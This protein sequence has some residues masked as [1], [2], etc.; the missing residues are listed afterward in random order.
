M[1]DDAFVVLVNWLRTCHSLL[2][3]L[4]VYIL[5]TSTI[6]LI[7]K[8][9]KYV[10]LCC[11][12]MLCGVIANIQVLYPTKYELMPFAVLLG[13]VVFSSTFLAV[14]IINKNYGEKSA[15]QSVLLSIVCNV[16]FMLNMILMLG[17]KPLSGLGL[18][19]K[20]DALSQIFVP[21]GRVILASYISFFS[22][23]ITEIALLKFMSKSVF[24]HNLSLFMSSVIVDNV[25]FTLFAFVLFGDGSFTTQN[26]IEVSISAIVVR[27]FCNLLNTLIYNAIKRYA[28]LGKDI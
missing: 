25:V 19:E 4:L 6:I 24:L 16:F 26:A 5:C 28:R 27:I 2:I 1:L 12:V 22:A 3:S 17:H 7:W 20:A 13:T 23:Q 8:Y 18:D 9:F 21:Q 10:G 15:K 14:D 11:Y